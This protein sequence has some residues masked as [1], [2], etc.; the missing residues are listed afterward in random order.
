MAV[1]VGERQVAPDVADVGEIAEQ[2]AHDRLGAPAVG[3]LEVPVLDDGHRP[4]AG[5][6]DVIALGIDLGREVREQVGV[7]EQGAVAA[8]LREQVRDP[9]GRPR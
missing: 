8:Q 4:I 9:E 7:A 6:A 2:L 3:T 5:A 1:D